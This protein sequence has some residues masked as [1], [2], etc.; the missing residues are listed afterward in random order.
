MSLQQTI[1]AAQTVLPEKDI[2]IGVTVLGFTQIFSGTLAV[3]VCQTVLS[4]TLNSQLASKLRGFDT[5]AIASSGATDI[6]NLVRPDQL[7][8]VLKAYNTA[9]DNL[10]YVSLAF[11][12]VAFLSSMFVEW[13]T[14]RKPTSE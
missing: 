2:P 9:I 13:K 14:V 1:N 12:C 4:N 8:I 11:A 7:P 3:P 10:F 5:K 6:R